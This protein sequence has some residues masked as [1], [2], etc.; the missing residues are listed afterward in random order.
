V[1]AAREF[2]DQM[3]VRVASLADDPLRRT[4]W[5]DRLRAVQPD[6]AK[7]S[8]AAE[9]VAAERKRVEDQLNPSQGKP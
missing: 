5:R 8:P 2:L 3:T 4:A 6:L 7:Q 1:P 9:V